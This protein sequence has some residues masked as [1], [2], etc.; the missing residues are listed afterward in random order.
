MRV[1]VSGNEANRLTQHG[2]E[3]VGVVKCEGQTGPGTIGTME[4][5]LQTLPRRRRIKARERVTRERGWTT[6]SQSFKHLNRAETNF[7]FQSK[8]RQRKIVDEMYGKFEFST[9]ESSTV[10]VCH[11]RNYIFIEK[12]TEFFYCKIF[13]HRWLSQ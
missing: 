3:Y 10:S 6:P 5:I 8:V 4:V 7:R 12:S 9:V 1:N 11:F 2:D 13:G